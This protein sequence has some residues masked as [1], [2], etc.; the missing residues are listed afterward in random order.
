MR[1]QII[2]KGTAASFAV[3]TPFMISSHH[4]SI[5][6][7]NVVLYS[8]QFLYFPF[9]KAPDILFSS[10]PLPFSVTL[11]SAMRNVPLF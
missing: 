3:T 1:Q 9:F 6:R 11:I 8:V 5:S 10:M 2:F 4:P 7:A